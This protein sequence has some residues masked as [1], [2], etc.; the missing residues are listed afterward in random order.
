MCIIL[1]IFYLKNFTRT[2]KFL[3]QITKT[4]PELNVIPEIY[5]LKTGIHNF[6]KSQ[7]RKANT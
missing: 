6:P 7:T 5:F 4:I 1:L 3:F 2:K